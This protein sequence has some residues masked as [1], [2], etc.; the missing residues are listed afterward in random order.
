[1]VSKFVNQV[2]VLIFFLKHLFSFII[3]KKIYW[4]FTVFLK[5]WLLFEFKAEKTE[6]ESSGNG[7]IEQSMSAVKP[8]VKKMQFWSRPIT[9]NK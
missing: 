1:M 5:K 6:L 8:A 7:E 9:E 2:N 4:R 3:M